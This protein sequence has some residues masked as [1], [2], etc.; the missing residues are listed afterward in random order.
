[1]KATKNYNNIVGEERLVHIRT[2]VVS[3]GG[4]LTYLFLYTTTVLEC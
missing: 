2:I 4:E 3:S 1:M